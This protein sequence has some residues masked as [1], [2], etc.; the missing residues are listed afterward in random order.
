MSRVV[1]SKFVREF[2]LRCF[3]LLCRYNPEN[4]PQLEAYVQL[5]VSVEV[6]KFLVKENVKK[7][8]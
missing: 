8:E 2:Y 5:Q 4:L 6:L 3:V 7:N 1:C